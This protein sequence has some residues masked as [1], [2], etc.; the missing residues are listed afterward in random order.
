MIHEIALM[1]ASVLAVCTI[2]AISFMI[3]KRQE[4]RKRSTPTRFNGQRKNKTS[5]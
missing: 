1:A 5:N 4:R 3:G 2:A